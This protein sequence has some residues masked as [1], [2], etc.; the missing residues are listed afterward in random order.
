M[1]AK[2]SVKK[3]FSVYQDVFPTT[4]SLKAAPA[5]ATKIV[6]QEFAPTTNAEKVLH[7]L[8]ILNHVL[9]RISVAVEYVLLRK[10]E[11]LSVVQEV[12]AVFLKATNVLRI[13]I[14]AQEIAI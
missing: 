8:R 4:V 13:W 3:P 9:C 5:K 1:T 2:C 10:V 14:V 7:V 6:V 11:N 12:R